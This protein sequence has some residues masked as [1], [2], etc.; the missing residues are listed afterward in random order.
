MRVILIFPIVVRAVCGVG[1]VCGG[2]DYKMTVFK[3]AVQK[4]FLGTETVRTLINRIENPAAPS[5]LITVAARLIQRESTD[6]R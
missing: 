1:L 4:E 2:G 6:R 3:R 5:R